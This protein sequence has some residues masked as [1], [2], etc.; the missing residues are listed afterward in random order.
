MEL[1]ALANTRISTNDAQNLPDHCFSLHYDYDHQNE[2]KLVILCLSDVMQASNP[3][4]NGSIR[5]S[6]FTRIH[7]INGCCRKYMLL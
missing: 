1:V 2:S 6:L 3:K 4:I 7:N 5:Q